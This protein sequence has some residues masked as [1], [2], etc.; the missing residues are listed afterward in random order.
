MAAQLT[1]FKARKSPQRPVTRIHGAQPPPA[2]GTM[3]VSCPF[4]ELWPGENSTP[5]F[6]GTAATTDLVCSCKNSH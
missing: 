2:Q 6:T 4:L 5:S 1:A 3:R